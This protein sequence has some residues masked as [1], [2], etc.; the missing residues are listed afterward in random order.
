MLRPG[1]RFVFA[2]EPTTVG[3]GY[4]RTLADADL[5]G[6]TNVTKL[7]G[8]ESWRRPQA[9]LDENSRAAAL[10][11]IVDLHTLLRPTWRRWPGPPVPSTSTPRPSSSPPRCSVGRCAPSSTTV[12]PGKLGWGWARFRVQQLED[13]QLGRRQRLAPRGTEGLVLQRRDH[14]GQAVLNLGLDD[15]AYLTSDEGSAALAVVGALPLTDRVGEIARLRKQFGDRTAVLVETV[16]LRRRAS[17]KL[18]GLPGTQRLAVHRRRAT[19][20]QRSAGCACIGQ[21]GCAAT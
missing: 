3:N 5:A 11:W 4:A 9:D 2:G 17:A 14:R 19:A 6:R 10:E 13:A 8:F 12:P 16:L 7:P 1:G 15:V 21:S 20:G 18:S